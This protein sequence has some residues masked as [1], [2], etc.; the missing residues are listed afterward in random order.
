MSLHHITFR[1][2]L[3]L[4]LTFNECKICCA[5][6]CVCIKAACSLNELALATQRTTKHSN[7]LPCDVV[8][9]NTGALVISPADGSTILLQSSLMDKWLLSA[10]QMCPSASWLNSSSWRDSQFKTQISSILHG[11]A[12]PNQISCSPIMFLIFPTHHTQSAWT[13]PSNRSPLPA[14]AARNAQGN[15]TSLPETSNL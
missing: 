15:R 1:V 5:L 13:A 10:S 12:S 4:C 8:H 14:Y 3:H 2:Q 9:S 11:P 6:A 7:A